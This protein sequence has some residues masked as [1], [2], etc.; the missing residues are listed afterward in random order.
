M[1]TFKD[2]IQEKI[3]NKAKEAKIIKFYKKSYNY[4]IVHDGSVHERLFY[5]ENSIFY[6]LLGNYLSQCFLV[7]TLK[8][9]TIL[10]V[11]CL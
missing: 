9:T 11:I 8:A 7:G 2:I 1:H 4:K 3:I 6:R 5:C 10:T